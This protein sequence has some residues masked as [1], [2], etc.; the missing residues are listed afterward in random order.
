M[1]Q[2]P[3]QII[4]KTKQTQQRIIPILLSLSKPS[5]II[6]N[7]RWTVGN[8]TVVDTN[9]LGN[10]DLPNDILQLDTPFQILKYFFT[11][12][13]MNHIRSE[14]HKCG[15]QNNFSS[16]LKMSNEDLQKLIGVLVIKSVVNITN[17]RK[18]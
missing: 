15:I 16:P 7:I 8:F 17:I 18:W 4:K 10:S 12:D 2:S 5:I 6:Q 9:F 1:N 14:T 13:L 3:Y 11:S